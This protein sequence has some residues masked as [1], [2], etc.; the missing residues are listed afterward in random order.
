MKIKDLLKY[1]NTEYILVANDEN[2]Y[3][4]E[5][6][7]LEDLSDEIKNSDLKS[8]EPVVAIKK[9]LFV[10]NAGPNDYVTALKIITTNQPILEEE[11]IKVDEVYENE[12]ERQQKQ[13]EQNSQQQGGFNQSPFGNSGS[14]GNF[15]N[16]FNSDFL[17]GLFTPE[18][19]ESFTKSDAFKD[20][21]SPE[22]IS[23]I[24]QSPEFQNFMNNVDISEL[25]RG[26][27]QSS[28][29]TP[30]TTNEEPP[31]DDDDEYEEI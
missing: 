12:T 1:L 21:M 28:P 26:M 23:E 6:L 22:R 19:F 10:N 5:Y 17:N 15:G 8:I 4:I 29:F 18:M 27:G 16:L 14:F 9:S 20:M 11:T 2:E 7:L 13:Y 30:P 3:F 31:E 24:I 25:M